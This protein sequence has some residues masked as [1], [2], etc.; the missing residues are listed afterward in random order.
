[1]L[2]LG[3]AIILAVS[4]CTAGASSPASTPAHTSGVKPVAGS[5]AACV[6][7]PKKVATSKDTQSSK[8]MPAALAA[9]YNAAMTAE[10]AK[11]KGSVPSV[12]VGVRNPK[13][14]WTKAY[15][16]AD[17]ATKTPSSPNMYQRIGSVTKTF[18]ATAVLQLADKGKLSLDDPIDDYVAGVPGGSRITLRELIAMT[19][20]LPSYSDDPQWT[21][22]QLSDPAEPWT[23]QQ[24]LAV[25]YSMP[26]SFSPGTS[27]QYSNTNYILLGLVIEQVTGKSLPDVITNQIL[28]PLRM[29]STSF[30]TDASFP[31]PHPRGYTHDLNLI[32]GAIPTNEWADATDWDTSWAWAAGSMVS[33]VGD[34]LTWGRVL[35]TGQGVL[36]TSAQVQRLSSF[37]SLNVAGAVEFYGD[38]FV[39]RNGWIGHG[40]SITGYNSALRYNPSID[41][42][43]VVEATGDGATTTPPLVAYSDALASALATVTGRP[44]PAMIVSKAAPAQPPADAELD[45]EG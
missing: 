45:S 42:T 26:T 40:G 19:S 36:P 17:I 29:S 9:K 38:G 32:I 3:T 43:I 7:N 33:Q 27:F 13:G 21:S 4:G 1:V 37:G 24:L 18:V 11:V 14:T 39:C 34:L 23:P 8:P 16:L 10:F 25:A 12:I 2:G 28:K 31:S 44:Y 20:G 15:G 35:A 5:A 41:T 22:D 6:P 30:P